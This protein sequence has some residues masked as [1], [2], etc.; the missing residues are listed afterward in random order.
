MTER[1]LAWAA[2][3][4]EGEGCISIDRFYR[5]NRM[6]YYLRVSLSNTDE[7]IIQFFNS[8]WAGTVYKEKVRG[9][10]RQCYKW[11][12]TGKKAE[13][14]LAQ[15]SSYFI[16][17]KYQERAKVAFGFMEAKRSKKPALEE[18]MYDRS[19]ILNKVGLQI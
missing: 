17:H 11:V 9:N 18:D 10:C 7:D 12:L 8:R 19:R 4:F 13:K 6:Q 3:C 16:T 15:F 5:N 14:C 2:G 1:E